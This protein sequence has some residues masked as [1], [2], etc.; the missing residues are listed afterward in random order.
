MLKKDFLPS[1]FGGVYISIGAL[2]YLVLEKSLA[3]ALF[4]SLGILLCIFC[5]GHLFTRAFPLGVYTRFEK[6]SV[7]QIVIVYIGNF[8]GTL[9]MAFLISQTFLNDKIAGLTL[10]VAQAKLADTFLS[11]L[12]SGTFAGLL[13]AFAVMFKR[14]EMNILFVVVTVAAFVILGFD[15]CIANMFYYGV[16][17]VNGGAIR[18]SAALDLLA[19]TLGN[20]IGGGIAAFLEPRG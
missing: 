5:N 11:T 3:G 17:A 7:R 20:M 16:F 9:L 18:F 8:I 10:A 6:Y 14:R 12:I 15:H 2:I 4:F 13:V 1:V 19:A